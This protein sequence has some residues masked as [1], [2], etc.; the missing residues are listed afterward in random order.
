MGGD[1]S[2]GH[3]NPA[4]TLGVYFSRKNDMGKNFFLACSM[5]LSQITGAVLGVL[6]VLM[7]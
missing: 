7:S 6:V 4:V 2:G 5:I 3:V 1:V